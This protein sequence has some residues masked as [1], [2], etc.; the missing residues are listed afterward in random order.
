MNKLIP[1]TP[2]TYQEIDPLC[3]DRD[4]TQPRQEIAQEAQDDLEASIRA[5]GICVPLRV[6]A[7]PDGRYLVCSGERR[8]RA[9]LALELPLVPC[10]VDPA[11]RTWQDA[12]DRQVVENLY[13]VDLRPLDLAQT[14]WRRLLGANIAALETERGE[15]GSGTAQQLA[16]AHTPT[17]QIAVLEARLC[18]LAGVATVADYFG[19][20]TVRVPRK[21]L[22]ADMGL[23]R[24]S[25]ARLRTLFQTLAVAPAV[26]DMLAG[27]DVAA[28]T[29]RGL[30]RHD[31]QTQALLVAQAQ[32]AAAEGDGAVGGT[33]RRA[34]AQQ[35]APTMGAMPAPPDDA[36][37]PS[38][39]FLTRSGNAPKLVTNTPPP[40][41][42]RTPPVA[43]T[44]TWDD[45]TVLLL[46][47]AL[48]TACTICDDA[49]VLRLSPPQVQRLA[50]L[51]TQLDAALQRAGVA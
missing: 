26:Q 27:I 24:W 7:K 49:R 42:G 23:A 13:R 50:P 32:Q 10:L 33:L 12:L 4:P 2:R 11:Q 19:G 29:L 43:P 41:R 44:G 18:A 35:D 28:R 25:E 1:S 39:A 21:P 9:A 22:L 38:L 3:I 6:V 36:P 48:E 15:D 5:H 40:A 8:L 30:A 31:P 45:D 46:E 37:D 17:A 51:W 14:L 16:A 47:G 20:E 34:L